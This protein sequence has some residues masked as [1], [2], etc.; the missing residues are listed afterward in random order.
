MTLGP[1]VVDTSVH[2]SSEVFSRPGSPARE[3]LARGLARHFHMAMSPALLREITRKLVE[4]GSPASDVARYIANLRRVAL[5]F[6]DEDPS[7][8]VCSDPDDLFVVALA[9]TSGA[10]CIVAQ[11][12]ALI[13][14]T[15]LPP[16]CTPGFFLVRLRELLGEP[17]G[18]RFP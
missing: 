3:V 16:G 6:D 1:F 11:D 8:F 7:G 18:K 5:L 9:H 12:G 4:T 14:T 17:A 10:W 13:Q 15:R 2:I